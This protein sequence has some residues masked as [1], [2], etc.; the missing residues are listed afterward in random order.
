MPLT[1][2]HIK[3]DSTNEFHSYSLQCDKNSVSCMQCQVSELLWLCLDCGHI[4]CSR[5]K[6]KH[7]LEHYKNT[8]HKTSMDLKTFRVWDYKEETYVAV[9][10]PTHNST[11]E[12]PPCTCPVCEYYKISKLNN[13]DTTTSCMSCEENDSLW[14]CLNCK[15][16]GCSRR[17]NRHAIIHYQ[18]TGHSQVMDLISFSIWDYSEGKYVHRAANCSC[19]KNTNSTDIVKEDTLKVEI[20]Q[21]QRYDER[22]KRLENEWKTFCQLKETNRQ[23]IS[24]EQ[25]LITLSEEKKLL[26][27]KLMEHDSKL[28]EL[29]SQFKDGNQNDCFPAVVA[30]STKSKEITIS[31]LN[32]DHTQLIFLFMLLLFLFSFVQLVI[33]AIVGKN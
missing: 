1:Y 25:R 11:H 20:K 22:I 4:G 28:N 31:S 13:K 15:H 9:K 17:K 8:G 12:C 5:R 23:M 32:M 27:N 10:S 26:E 6:N 29:L 30:T 18:Q 7:A 14:L 21:D 2:T 33:Q 19:L 24:I 16:L 3:E